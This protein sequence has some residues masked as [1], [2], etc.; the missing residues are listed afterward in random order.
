M[1]VY[2]FNNFYRVFA[3]IELDFKKNGVHILND[4]GLPKGEIIK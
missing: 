1:M 3:K 4:L 2:R